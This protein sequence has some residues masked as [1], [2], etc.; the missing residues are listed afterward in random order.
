MVHDD[1]EKSLRPTHD[2][3]ERPTELAGI[4]GGVARRVPGPS[5]RPA[6]SM[7]AVYKHR[8]TYTFILQNEVAS[9][10]FDRQRGEVFFRGHNVKFMALEPE[11]RRALEELMTVLSQDREGQGLL[12]AYRETLAHLLADK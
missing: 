6:D 1:R 8:F 10:H 5:G 2:A 12:S 11:Q 9:I 7:L 4:L 3:Q